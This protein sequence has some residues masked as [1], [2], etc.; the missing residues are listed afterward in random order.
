LD[1]CTRLGYRAGSL[2]REGKIGEMRRWDYR[3]SL[4]NP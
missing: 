4:Q 2:R 1:V 3:K